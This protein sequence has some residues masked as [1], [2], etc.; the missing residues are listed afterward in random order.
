MTFVRV[1]GF[2]GTKEADWA[3]ETSAHSS[4]G[5]EV[6]LKIGP[7]LLPNQSVLSCELPLGKAEGR[8]CELSVSSQR[9]WQLGARVLAPESGMQAVLDTATTGAQIDLRLFSLRS[10]LFHRI[11]AQMFQRRILGMHPQ[12]PPLRPQVRY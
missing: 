5:A 11:R 1:G 2:Q 7:F 12:K 8:S 4:S 9:A 10:S 6:A 3:T